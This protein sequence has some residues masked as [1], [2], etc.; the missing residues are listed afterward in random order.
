MATYQFEKQIRD[1][2]DIR[3]NT[4]RKEWEDFF[5][6]GDN[7]NSI[8]TTPAGQEKPPKSFKRARRYL[9]ATQSSQPTQPPVLSAAPLDSASLE[10]RDAGINYE[11]NIN[12]VHIDNESSYGIDLP[13]NLESALGTLGGRLS[14]PN[15]APATSQASLTSLL[16]LLIA[17][18]P[19][20]SDLITPA[21]GSPFN[22]DFNF[23]FENTLSTLGDRILSPEQAVSPNQVAARSSSTPGFTHYYGWPG[24]SPNRSHLLNDNI[25]LA[26]T[27]PQ[28]V[29]R[30]DQSHS[31]LVQGYCF[32]SQIGSENS[33]IE[34]PVQGKITFSSHFINF[35]EFLRAKGV[36][37][38]RT[39]LAG[40]ESWP[41]SSG[42]LTSKFIADVVLSK[43]QSSTRSASDLEMAL[44]RLGTLIPGESTALITKDQ[45]FE[46]KF[47]RILL[48]SMLN[49]FAGL[50]HIPVENMLNFLGR[51]SSI[52]RSFFMVLKESSTP[53]ART[54]VDTI[55]RAS[56]EVKDKHTLK[57]L[58]EHRLVD[59]NET[60]C[61]FKSYR[62]TPI[63]RAAYLQAYSLVA[64]LLQYGANLN[65]T[66]R[67]QRGGAL[68]RLMEGLST[69]IGTNRTGITATN[70]ITEMVDLLVGTG[71]RVDVY[72]VQR[73]ARLFT[74]YD[75]V[76]RLSLAIL[77]S[78]HRPFFAH[79]MYTFAIVETAK[80][81]D[82]TLASQIIRNMIDLCEKDRCGRCL[83][84]CADDVE[85]ATI[86]AAELGQLKVVQLLISHVPSST[87]VFCAAIRSNRKDLIDL[88]L[89]FKP[90]L[91]TSLRDIAGFWKDGGSTP[92]A[93]AV[94]LGNEELIKHLHSV[95][96]FARLN[97]RRHLK[98]LI[99]VAARLGD[100]CLMR[101]LLSLSDSSSRP[102]RIPLQAITIALENGHEEV[103]WLLLESGAKIEGALCA[104]LQRRN[105]PLIQAILNASKELIDEKSL[106]EALEWGDM[107]IFE[108]LMSAGCKTRSFPLEGLCH[109]CMR[110]GNTDFFQSSV[111]LVQL[112]CNLDLQRCLKEAVNMGHSEM[113]CYLL[114]IGAN[115]FMSS[116]L[117]AA[118]PVNL[119]MLHLLFDKSRPRRAVPKCIG[120][121]VLSSVMDE[122]LGN[123]QAFDAL[124]RT[125]AVNLKAVEICESI[126]TE[127]SDKCAVTPLGLVLTS[128]LKTPDKDA[129][130]VRALLD[131]GSDPNGVAKSFYYGAL[132]QDNF[133]KSYTGLMLALETTRR[134]IV[135]LLVDKGAD[136]NRKPQF[137]VKRTP[138][139]YAAELGHLD[140]VRML[141]EQGAEVNAEPAMRGGGTALQLAAISG[142]CNVA[143]ELLAS[144]ASLGALP[145][146][147][148]GRWPLEGA[149]EYGRL[150]MIQFLWDVAT[151]RG[152][153]DAVLGFQ[154]RHCL[155]AM[156]FAR[157]NGHMGCRDLISDLSGIPINR[158]DVENYGAPWLAYNDWNDPSPPSKWD[159]FFQTG[160]DE[161][162]DDGDDTD[163][164]GSDWYMS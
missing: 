116:I 1:V 88:V 120:A 141:L 9:K 2:W 95:G 20:V 102:C 87:G 81:L 77:P 14:S 65:K 74:T 122:S 115:P 148:D 139:Q 54:F 31:S 152:E 63:E 32:Q 43:Q 45:G 100:I 125:R 42:G 19:L 59:V 97:D 142:N 121:S 85:R 13:F 22:F 49:G 90:D 72:D 7:L 131:A 17:D 61:F 161:W 4:K 109:R 18:D 79:S 23:D 105:K 160:S 35:E 101:K 156:N 68:I 28:G 62:Y 104:A 80:Y 26:L 29:L 103:A 153:T 16:P 94:R 3:K 34:L 55:F 107:S 44:S 86:E 119:E 39:G 133:I 114:D 15:Q 46:T 41:S 145:S 70:D 136:I 11:I 37:F 69:G 117:E 143:I 78:D 110:D 89:S 56:I 106:D 58:L 6:Q 93:E 158:L 25:E 140:M 38:T 66:W 157:E 33:G 57:Q 130:M 159:A 60:V 82:D 10:I 147:V 50:N 47:I 53:A 163:E 27:C 67:K 151:A 12:P 134:E 112:L 146:K 124:L 99:M 71:A 36:S 30:N 111:E 135:Q 92:L 64:T 155:R 76:C 108:D 126:E 21:P 144:G 129:W 91:N 123:P 40:A 48:F 73:A 5:E 154:R 132:A 113:V 128:L 83:V 149:A 164:M 118:L 52:S 24:S 138:L 75:I 137:A 127:E 98:P 162:I 96:A 8:Q 51:L 150:D 84:A